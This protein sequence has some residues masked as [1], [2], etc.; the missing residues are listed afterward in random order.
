MNE[1]QLTQYQWNYSVTS[2]VAGD[3]VTLGDVWMSAQR[4]IELLKK[5]DKEVKYFLA[6][7]KNSREGRPHLHGVIQTT[8]KE[9]QLKACFYSYHSYTAREIKDLQGWLSYMM[10]QVVEDCYL[11]NIGE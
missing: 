1:Q 7:C 11:T 10:P 2:G 4:S 5:N 6:V 3:E 8:L 9:Y